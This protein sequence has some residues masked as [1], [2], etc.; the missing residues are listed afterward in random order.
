MKRTV[1]KS[2][3]TKKYIIIGGLALVAL[4]CGSMLRIYMLLHS[5]SGDIYSL[6]E[7][8]I[9]TGSRQYALL[10][11]QGRINILILGEDNVEGSKRSDTIL[12]ATIDINDNNMRVLALPRDTRAEIPRH[13][14]QKMN[15]AYAYGGVDLSKAMVE[16]YLD[17]PILYYFIIDFDSF[18]SLV[19]AMGGI[20]IDV[21][22]RMKYVDRAGGVDIDIQSGLQTMDGKTALNFV[23][24]RKDALGDIG[25]IQRQ[26]QF[27]KAILKRA[28]DPR[29]IIRVPEIASEA[30]KVIKTDMSPTLAVQL[31]GFIQNEVGRER[32]FFSTLPGTPT[33]LDKLSYWLGDRDAGRAFLEAPTEELV[34]RDLKINGGRFAGVSIGY[35]SAFDDNDKLPLNGNGQDTD[36]KHDTG[37]GK[38]ELL[39]L[40]KAVSEPV[41]ILNGSGKGGVASETAT[42]LQ[43]LGIDVVRTGNAKHFD[44]KYSNVI[45]PPNAKPAD[46][47][48]AKK[49]GELMEIPN[50]LVRPNNQAAY[51]SIIVG[52][53]YAGVIAKLDVMLSTVTN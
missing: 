49:L 2:S 12:F 20:E 29:N 43:K 38:D 53:D 34:T 42:R 30:M 7:K 51:P 31:A 39:K 47:D 48:S 45:Y 21:Q 24:F 44:Y 33:T 14:F 6:I 4:I 16:R 8:N 36:K 1:K 52:Q 27:M 17:Q 9:N 46:V 22:K 15:H 10:K 19:D 32:I 40:I 11:E 41:A 23:R 28:Y 18:P 37:P 3:K 13:G 35:S 25:R 5:G 26:Q 50:N